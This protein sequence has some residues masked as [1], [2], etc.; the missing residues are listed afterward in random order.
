MA[1]LNVNTNQVGLVGVT[2]NIVQIATNDTEAT[3]LTTG[4]LNHIVQ[5]GVSFPMPCLAEVST[6]ASAG[7]Q[8]QVG[9]FQIS[10]VGRNWSLIASENP[11]NVILPT[12]ATRIA[13]YTDAIGTLSMG[14]TA[15]NA[16]LIQSGLST[17]GVAG[18]FLAYSATAAHGYLSMAAAVNATGNFNTIVTNATAIAQTQTLSI[19]DTGAATGNFILSGITGSGI[20]HITRGSLQVD[21]GALQ[22]GI[23]TGGFP[24][25]LQA[26]S[27]TAASG[28]IGMQAASNGSGNF[29]LILSN[30]TAQAQ[31]TTLTFPDVVNAAGRV[32]VAATA[33]PFTTGHILA[34]SGTGGLVV[35]SGVA[36]TAVQ[37][38]TNIKAVRSADIGGGGAGPITI[39]QAG[40]VATSVI[41]ANIVS[42][43][44][45]VSI[46]KVTPGTGNF[47]V[48]FSGDPGA[49]CILNY[50]VF[51]AQQ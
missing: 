31:A 19:P 24:G 10:H 38:N 9:W 27:N 3:I 8:P 45:T 37:L 17:G 26:F 4:Y 43:S 20:Q 40:V 21:G 32:L 46:A 44:N 51:I 13:V 48:L 50:I 29:G 42:S 15:V 7:A 6:V 33:T 14:G 36:T 30:N 22:S 28:F 49:A 35:D 1:I 11:G 18:Q 41:V 47:T 16:G 12:V 34:S 2:P 5:S 39:T 25:L 23:S